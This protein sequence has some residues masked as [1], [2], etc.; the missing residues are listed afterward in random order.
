MRE[1]ERM[2][3]ALVLH[4]RTVASTA[5]CIESLQAQG[6]GRLQLVDN[7]EDGGSSLARLQPHL[8]RARSKGMQ[9]Q[10][11]Q[12][13][14]NL[15]F[16]GGVNRGLA[17][18]REQFGRVRVLLINS[19][20][21]L[22]PGSLAPMHAEID[23]GVGVVAPLLYSPTGEAKSVKYYHR[24]TGLLFDRPWPGSFPHLSGC[25][26]L[27]S[28]RIVAQDLLNERFFF[29][30]E[31]AYLGWKLTHAGVSAHVVPVA[32]ALHFGSG[33]SRRGSL[34]YEYHMARAHLELASELA[35]SRTD[36]RLLLCGRCVTLPLRALWRSARQRSLVPIK[37]LIIAVQDF[38]SGTIQTMTPPASAAQS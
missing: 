11:L 12:P 1:T 17:D 20:A 38:I 8:E 15:G 26:L 13:G 21:Q 5:G 14:R 18:I 22:M 6:L 10:V 32:G 16:S 2:T 28:E 9:V 27:L 29:Y 34:F 31:D 19:D 25:C 23:A 24:V 30:G 37:G 7:S 35:K 33:S 3:V 36:R 4:F